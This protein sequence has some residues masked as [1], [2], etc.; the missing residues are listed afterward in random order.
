MGFRRL[1]RDC[2]TVELREVRKSGG[3]KGKKGYQVSTLS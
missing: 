1:N 2:L 3:L